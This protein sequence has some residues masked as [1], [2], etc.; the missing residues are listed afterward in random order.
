MTLQT[1]P[2]PP[3]VFR[4]LKQ[5]WRDWLA[6]GN[7][8]TITV[9]TPASQAAASPLT[10]TGTV[11]VDPSVPKP[12]QIQAVLNNGGTAVAQQNTYANTTTGAW[13]IT[14]PGGSCPA[15]AT[16]NVVAYGVTGGA[17]LGY[18]VTPNFTLT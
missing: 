4:Y 5:A 3:S 12:V 13:T 15:T 2:H 17:I 7:A 10:V 6:T 9:S 18:G 14:Y 8:A 11:T 16:A 1:A